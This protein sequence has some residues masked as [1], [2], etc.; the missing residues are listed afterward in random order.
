MTKGFSLLEVLI[1]LTLS[2]LLLGSL[3]ESYGAV[4]RALDDMQR[5]ELILERGIMA[6]ELITTDIS[7]AG[8]FGCFSMRVSSIDNQ[9]SLALFPALY[10]NEEGSKLVTLYKIV[11][12]TDRCDKQKITENNV[13]MHTYF[14]RD[15][16]RYEAGEKIFALYR[17]DLSG[18][19]VEL[20]EKVSD[21]HVSIVNKTVTV[22]FTLHEKG[23]IKSWHIEAQRMNG[24]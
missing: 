20:I 15:T 18:S 1:A 21:F 6:R 9:T 14:V 19:S 10:T 24:I 2:L 22:D 5:L 23:L 16:G 13:I 12:E 3:M 11:E 17:E 7:M 4:K 8:Y